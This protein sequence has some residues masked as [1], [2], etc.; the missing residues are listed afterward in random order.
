MIVERDDDDD[1]YTLTSLVI[2]SM[3]IDTASEATITIN[4]ITA[5]AEAIRSPFN[6]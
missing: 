6:R 1:G 5:A 4:T 2:T 3:A